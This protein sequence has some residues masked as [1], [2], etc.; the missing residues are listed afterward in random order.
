MP[1]LYQSSASWYDPQGQYANFVVSGSADGSA[2]LVPRA[3]IIALAGP[4][5]GTYQFESFTVMVWD[6]TCSRCSAAR[7]PASPATSA[8]P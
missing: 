6:G 7:R 4:P 3:D 5:A 8:H 1:R 2:D